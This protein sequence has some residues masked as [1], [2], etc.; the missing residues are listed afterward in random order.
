MTSSE[1]NLDETQM[2]QDLQLA[3]SQLGIF[4]ESQLV[5][6]EDLE[7]NMLSH[8]IDSMCDK[9][10][11]VCS[12]CGYEVDPFRA[13][14]KSKS[15]GNPSYVCNTCNSKATMLSRSTQWPVP[16]FQELSNEEKQ[17]FWRKCATTSGAVALKGALVNAITHSQVNRVSAKLGGEYLPL[18]VYQQKGFDIKEIEAKCTDTMTHPIFGTVYRV[19]ILGMTRAS[20]AEDV[21]KSVQEKVEHRSA[22][23][24]KKLVDAAQEAADQ[25][26]EEEKAIDD[27][28][29]SDSSDSSSGSS[30]ESS[31][32]DKKK[33]K[34]KNKKSSRKSKSS[35]AKKAAKKTKKT[36]A[37][38]SD[39]GKTK[40]EQAALL[41]AEKK[42]E[43]EQ[44]K[45]DAKHAREQ[46][47]SERAAIAASRKRVQDA[48][49]SL[50][51]SYPATVLAR[52]NTPTENANGQT[53]AK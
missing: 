10:R 34:K 24:P 4:E 36:R 48:Q 41:R 18:S 22:K 49:K 25:D 11:P 28:D 5:P 26:A 15:A 30:S 53:C 23:L 39:D 8:S 16:E 21:R 31:S 35:K 46:A 14:I 32:S 13:Q 20:E 27:A 17:D 1:G 38:G 37:K 12:R 33:K 43:M 3:Q 50:T 9:F 52:R 2:D 29:V 47:A 45:I 42:L 40:K 7:Q 51:A 44:K 6:T 19:Q